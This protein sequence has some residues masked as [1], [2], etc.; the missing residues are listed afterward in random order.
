MLIGLFCIASF[1]LGV[2]AGRALTRSL[3][4]LDVITHNSRHPYGQKHAA[5][6]ST[7]QNSNSSVLSGKSCLLYAVW[8]ETVV[9]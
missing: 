2:G 7:W 1:F 9:W 8:P 6:L 3:Y 5:S 4:F